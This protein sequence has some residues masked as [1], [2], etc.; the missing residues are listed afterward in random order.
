MADL[1]HKAPY[2]KRTVSFVVRSPRLRLAAQ[3]GLLALCLLPI[4][5]QAA[6]SWGDVGVL[7]QQVKAPALLASALA[8]GLSL[9]LQPVAMALFTRGASHRIGYRDSAI[10]Y[11]GSQ[12][13]KY[14]PGAFWILPGRVVL[15]RR[16]GRN[17]G[18]SSAALLFEMTAQVLSSSLVVVLLG[19]IR[20]DASWY[21]QAARFVL[22][23]SVMVS[24][25]L[26]FSPAWVARLL[27]RPS[28]LQQ[29][30]TSLSEVRPLVRLHNLVEATS[31]YV[32]MWGLMGVSFYALLVLG[33]PRLDLSLLELAVG[34]ST[35][36]WLAG[37]LTPFSPGGIGVRE[38]M[39]VLLLSPMM[40]APQAVMV[41]LLSR[42]L[43]LAAELA[44]FG[45]AF[46]ALRAAR[47]AESPGGE[48][49][50][51]PGGL[52]AEA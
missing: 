25:L 19:L 51:L 15:L 39:I 7:A 16:L 48:T 3:I 33:N 42:A 12:P 4:G 43:A 32:L 36:S 46:F 45:A 50:P 5:R 9:L 17:A 24:L 20:G 30:L 27:R 31:L 10:A 49:P 8:L 1:L 44:F 26:L 18:V 23:G 29:A 40:A 28:S 2:L 14:L 13:M 38:G 41:A 6:A 52:P 11:F 21:V 37:F 47:G 22:A 35:L 34:V